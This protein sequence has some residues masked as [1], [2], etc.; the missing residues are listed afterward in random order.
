[1]PVPRPME[2][3][4]PRPTH[5]T[6]YCTHISARC[7]SSA[8]CP[9]MQQPACSHVATCLQALTRGPSCAAMSHK[10]SFAAPMTEL[11]CMA[12]ATAE[13]SYVHAFQCKWEAEGLCVW[14]TCVLKEDVAGNGGQEECEGD[15]VLQQ[16]QAPTH[17][18]RPSTCREVIQCA[19][20]VPEEAQLLPLCSQL[21]SQLHHHSHKQFQ[22]C[23]SVILLIS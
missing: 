4:M 20:R 13:C 1:M 18:R 7:T 16:P 21:L 11:P 9:A 5:H 23:S 22:L 10:P 2:E 12:A 6:T 14:C 19:Y 17:S 3:R 15:A 8:C